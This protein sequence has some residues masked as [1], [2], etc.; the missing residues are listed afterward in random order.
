MSTINDT[1]LRFNDGK[2]LPDGRGQFTIERG[3]G[4]K[5]TVSATA[6]NL[7]DAVAYLAGMI[8][9]ANEARGSGTEG[10][11]QGFGLIRI[12]ATGMG[13]AASPDPEKSLVVVNLAGTPLG[14]EIPNSDLAR[15]AEGFSEVA[16]RLAARGGRPS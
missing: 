13:L 14:F 11:P 10:P 8:K 9:L 4:Q 5:F 15:L 12:P 2:I 6:S 16:N 7:A 1:L 3:D